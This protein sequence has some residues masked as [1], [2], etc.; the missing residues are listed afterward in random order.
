M[1]PVRL[2]CVRHAAS[3]HPEP[4]SNSHVLS[5]LLALPHPLA[6]LGLCAFFF[7]V[8]FGLWPLPL[9]SLPPGFPGFQ[10][11]GMGHCSVLETSVSENLQ[12]LPS[13][14][15]SGSHYCLFVKV[16]A[17]PCGNSDIISQPPRF[18][19]RFFYFFR[20]PAF[21]FPW[22]F[23]GLAGNPQGGRRSFIIT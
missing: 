14:E 23:Y 9:A 7:T 3:V 2:A 15:F 6:G 16:L 13:W 22:P 18:V 21:S 1:A 10:A 20:F 19:N 8:L 5:F 12:R 17:A 11:L 4:G